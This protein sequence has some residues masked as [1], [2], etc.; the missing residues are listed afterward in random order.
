MRQFFP[1][2][3]SLLLLPAC[4]ATRAQLPERLDEKLV[5]PWSQELSRAQ[6]LPPP[7]VAEFRSGA[8]SL[9][10]LAV[11]HEQDGSGKS[12]GLVK[13]V[14]GQGKYDV[15]L[16][17][18]FPWS[19]GMNPNAL[20]EM[21]SRD[22][23]NDFF[24]GG[25]ISVAV[26][27]AMSLKKAFYGA[28]PDDLAVKAALLAAG[29][30]PEDVLGFYVTRQIPQWERDGTLLQKSFDTAYLNFRDTFGRKL[31]LDAGVLPTPES[32]REW[33][34]KKNGEIFHA[35]DVGTET[36][37]P[38]V[39]GTVFTQ[40][41]SAVVGKVRDQHVVRVIDDMLEKK[42]SILVIFGASHYL[43]QRPA[44]E[45]TLGAP[46]SLSDQPL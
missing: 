10:Y 29:F 42:K 9:T 34:A 20:R 25:E 32:F 5:Q 37:A 11:E 22:G 19:K 21:A 39:D 13:K 45:A 44:L 26:Q 30:T 4:A 16:L 18:G 41:M 46:E 1:I 31:E 3:L 27:G 28:E 23:V 2:Y 12:L 38:Y 15:I 33:F 35:R 24:A 6:P 43:T 8:R 17:E 7:Y 14:V 36:V 40:K